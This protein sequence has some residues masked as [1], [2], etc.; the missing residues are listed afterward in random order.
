MSQRPHPDL[1]GIAREADVEIVV[2]E[3]LRV[4]ATDAITDVATAELGYYEAE[5]VSLRDAASATE[6]AET[7]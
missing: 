5:L 1:A 2:A 7:H 6:E 3:S 4:T